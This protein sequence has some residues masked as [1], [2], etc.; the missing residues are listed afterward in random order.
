MDTAAFDSQWRH[1]TQELWAEAPPKS[2]NGQADPL[3]SYPDS[4]HL[5]ALST[6]EAGHPGHPQSPRSPRSGTKLHRSIGLLKSR[7]LQISASA[8]GNVAGLRTLAQRCH[9]APWLQ[10]TLGSRAKARHP[11]VTG[12]RWSLL[13]M[14]Q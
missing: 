1:I 12:M 6:A 4:Y 11:K 5:I 10:K 7:E 9:L 2:G 13:T 3:Y 8:A 14:G